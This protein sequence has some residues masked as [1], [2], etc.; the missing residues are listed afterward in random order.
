MTNTQHIRGQREIRSM[1]QAAEQVHHCPELA[2]HH[3][4]QSSRRRG[5]YLSAAA[6]KNPSSYLGRQEVVAVMQE[7]LRRSGIFSEI[8]PKWG[9]PTKFGAYQFTLQ[10]N[11]SNPYR[12]YPYPR[13]LDYGV[14]TL[15]ARMYGEADEPQSSATL[16]SDT[17]ED[18]QSKAHTKPETRAP[19]PETPE[20]RGF[21]GRTRDPMPGMP[22]L[23]HNDAK[24]RG[25]PGQRRPDGSTMPGSRDVPE[26]FTPEQIAAMDLAEA[27]EAWSQVATALQR[28]VLD[29]ETRAR[30][31]NDFRAIKLRVRELKRKS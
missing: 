21:N 28:A 24:R 9:D 5:D 13:D 30:L 11:V 26:P 14:W 2:G 19:V 25:S 31:L 27:Q 17:V 3:V 22:M 29:E 12:R 10:A 7:N 8:H 18:S 20:K 23:G 16:V 4:V 6:S 15:A 1:E